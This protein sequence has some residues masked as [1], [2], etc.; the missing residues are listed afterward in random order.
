MT[1]MANDNNES[2]IRK[3]LFNEVSFFI[4]IIAVVIGCVLFISGP[5]AEMKMDIALMQ[6]SIEVIES[7]HLKTIQAD[8]NKLKVIETDIK[9]VKDEIA[10]INIKLERIIT[11]LEQ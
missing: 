6:Q 7:N 8:I 11:L 1:I 9:E 5:D 2:K 4:S 10:E 3:V